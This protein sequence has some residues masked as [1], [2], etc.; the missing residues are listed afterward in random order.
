MPRVRPWRVLAAALLLAT[1]LLGARLPQPEVAYAATFVVTTTQDA[2]H[3]SPIDGTCTSTLPGNLC[4]LRAAIQAANFLTNEP[5][6]FIGL[7]V[8]GTYVL[9]S[10]PAP[11]GDETAANGDLDIN[12]INLV[13]ANTS[14]GQVVIDGNHRDRVFDVG[15]IFAAVVSISGVTI[16][17][18]LARAGPT[19]SN[20]GQAQDNGN[21][22][23][24]RVNGGGDQGLPNSTLT[25]TNVVLDANEAQG[26]GGGLS[27]E[28]GAT[29]ILNRVQLTSNL[30]RRDGGGLSVGNGGAAVL[31]DVLVGPNGAGSTKN[32]ASS[33]P[34]WPTT[35]V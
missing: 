16:Q 26:D 11:N 14:G 23:G 12:A 32:Q 20:G 5:Q 4:T 10:G 27:V 15:P 7:S 2:P 13:I 9:T 18:G 34:G 6:N 19:T 29:V 22:G 28:P 30:A 21:G 31:S 33:C 25:L 8:A 3:T 35:A 1:A 17:H 24:I